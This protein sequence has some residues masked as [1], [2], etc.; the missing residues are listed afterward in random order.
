MGSN[1]NL[2]LLDRLQQTSCQLNFTQTMLF[3]IVVI[4][5]FNVLIKIYNISKEEK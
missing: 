3:M 1:V 5:F 2:E 4:F